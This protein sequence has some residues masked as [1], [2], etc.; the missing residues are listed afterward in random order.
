MLRRRSL[1]ALL[2]RSNLSGLISNTV[3]RSVFA[4]VK[5]QPIQPLF[6]EHWRNESEIADQI[7]KFEHLVIYPYFKNRAIC[8]FLLAGPGQQHI[9]ETTAAINFACT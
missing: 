8:P 2:V 5:S 9:H 3:D 7:N 4:L 1:D 6:G